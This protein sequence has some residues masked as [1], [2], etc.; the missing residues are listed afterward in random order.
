[1][2]EEEFTPASPSGASGHAVIDTIKAIDGRKFLL[3]FVIFVIFGTQIGAFT[4]LV[5]VS[6]ALVASYDGVSLIA[7]ILLFMFVGAFLG[8][9]PA[10]VAGATMPRAGSRWVL[11]WLLG[12]ML[13]SFLICGLLALATA[14]PFSL[15][16]TVGGGLAA[17]ACRELCILLKID[18]WQKWIEVRQSIEVRE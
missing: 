18:D 17:M 4:T 15:G 16:V 12:V 5:V 2:S 11:A 8:F 6:S 14:I 10:V 9:V 3:R 1:M 13:L 7:Q